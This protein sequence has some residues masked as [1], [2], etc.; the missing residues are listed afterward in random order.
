M[1][2]IDADQTDDRAD[3]RVPKQN[4]PSDQPASFRQD[5]WQQ[6]EAREAE[7]K[8]D[9]LADQDADGLRMDSRTYQLRSVA[10]WGPSDF[11]CT[12]LGDGY[13]LRWPAFVLRP[14]RRA[15]RAAPGLP[16]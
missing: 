10:I 4:S 1:P 16:Q 12:K 5:K 2:G 9:A 7:E 11:G 6:N 15:L 14:S 8:T 13:G 3:R